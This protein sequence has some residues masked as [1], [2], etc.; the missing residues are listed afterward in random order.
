MLRRYADAV[1]DQYCRFC[2]TCERACPRGVAVA[3]VMRYHMYFK[4][5]GRQKD[6]MR[7]YR[8][9][10]AKR[11]AVACRDCEAPCEGN[12]PFDRRIRAG[13]LEAHELLS[14]A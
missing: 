5:Y 1:R 3:D 13:L 6:S 7:L 12:C 14:F 10:P 4:Y 11:S 8:E 2:T 9:L